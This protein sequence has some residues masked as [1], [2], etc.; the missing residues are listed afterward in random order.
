VPKEVDHD[1]RR[2]E[3][4]TAVAGILADV[5]L[6]GLTIRSLAGRLGGSASVVTHYFPSRQSLLADI[7]P[8]I[9]KRWQSEVEEITAEGSDQRVLLRE[10]L[11]WLIPITPEGLMEE[12]AGLC[13]LVATES[14]GAAVRSLRTELDVWVRDLIRDHV[15]GLVHD[16]DLEPTVDMLYAATRGISVSACEHPEAWPAE[17]QM[18][19]LDDLLGAL[20]LLPTGS[21]TEARLKVVV[22]TE[23]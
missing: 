23:A 5:G 13:L 9:L 3:I 2:D 22:N 14:D 16:S 12:R 15:D 18:A 7:G 1:Q 21:R 19:V 10:V 4:L 20:G 8:W 11:A 6:R 17:R